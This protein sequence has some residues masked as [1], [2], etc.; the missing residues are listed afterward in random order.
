MPAPKSLLREVEGWRRALALEVSGEGAT[1]AELVRFV[2]GLVEGIVFLRLCELKGIEIGPS[3]RSLMQESDIC[4]G[5][6]GSLR[7]AEVS[8]GCQL[9]SGQLPGEGISPRNVTLPDQ[10]LRRVLRRLHRPTSPLTARVDSEILGQIYEQFLERGTDSKSA[11]AAMGPRRSGGVYYTPRPIIDYLVRHCLGAALRGLTPRQARK[12]R[13]LDPSCGGGSFLLGA[14]DF[15]FDWHL[16]WYCAH[17]PQLWAARKQPPLYKDEDGAWRLTVAA[18]ERIVRENIFGV[19]LDA[20][21]VAVTRRA[22]ILKVLEGGRE[23]GKLKALDLSDNIKRGNALIGSDFYDCPHLE[24]RA[25]RCS[26]SETERQRIGAFSWEQEF[27]PVFEKGG[28][29]AVIGNPPYAN[30]SSRDSLKAS[31]QRQGRASELEC[32]DLSLD[33]CSEKYAASSLGCK[34]LYKWFTARA[35]ELTRHGGQFGFIIPNTWLTQSKYADLKHLIGDAAGDLSLVDFGVGIFPVL[36]PTCLVVARKGQG[37][38]KRYAD[39]KPAR[40]KWAALENCH[41]ET[42]HRDGRRV[43]HPFAQKFL[44]QWPAASKMK[45]WV[46]LRE[47]LHIQRIELCAG[48]E[49]DQIPV[50]DSKNMGRYLFRWTPRYCYTNAPGRGAFKA[51]GGARLIVR[52]TGDSL[53]AT[54][55][56]ET[57]AFVLQSLYQSVAIAK[58]VAPE[59]LLGL[60][61]SKFLTFLYQ[62]S[63]FGQKGRVL[64]QLRKGH[65]DNLPVPRLNLSRPLDREKHDCLVELVRARLAGDVGVEAEIDAVVYGLYGLSEVEIAL[66]EGE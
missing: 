7:R 46:T 57:E 55:T 58:G 1:P 64:A 10:A 50:I 8:T 9:L 6:L 19:D 62:S 37:R 21:A 59:Y 5:L 35:L 24:T 41:F 29:D 63:E 30:Y 23:K 42:L 36:V 2:N 40:D 39:L 53:V 52:K 61:N 33:Y 65:L 28:F 25:R 38:L 22:L 45:S 13:V 31:Y 18:R 43:G 4:M 32:L 66:V 60:L 51:T 12:I 16:D 34:D 47:G 3:L 49:A 20:G 26:L 27:A 14:L 11:P 44:T 15:L 54:L 17:Q 56:P 48:D